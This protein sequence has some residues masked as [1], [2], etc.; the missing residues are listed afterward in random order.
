M[1]IIIGSLQE[2]VKYNN[3][4]DGAILDG[5]RKR[6]LDLCPVISSPAEA[7]AME[8][9][10]RYLYAER[11]CKDVFARFLPPSIPSTARNINSADIQT[12]LDALVRDG[13]VRSSPSELPL[14]GRA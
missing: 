7:T 14:C 8:N 1:G 10:L 2:F 12:H 6:R 3:E 5:L 11:R 4:H 13:W 9:K